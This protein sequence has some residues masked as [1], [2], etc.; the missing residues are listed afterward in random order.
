VTDKELDKNAAIEPLA[1]NVQ[2][3][4]RSLAPVVRT[5]RFLADSI[6]ADALAMVLAR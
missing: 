6:R 1:G 4:A 5:V 2:R 3:W